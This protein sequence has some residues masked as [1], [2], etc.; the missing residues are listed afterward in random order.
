MTLFYFLQSYEK[1]RKLFLIY[2]MWSNV[3]S[4]ILINTKLSDVFIRYGLLFYFASFFKN[5]ISLKIL[6]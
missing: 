3:V 2:E 5:F 4:N 6:G 1:T